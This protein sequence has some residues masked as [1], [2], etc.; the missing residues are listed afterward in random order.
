[1][2]STSVKHTNP[3]LDEN[4]DELVEKLKMSSLT[5]KEQ[6]THT[7]TLLDEAHTNSL[8][9]KNK[10]LKKNNH[11][12]IIVTDDETEKIELS[13]KLIDISTSDIQDNTIKQL[14]E[15]ELKENNISNI[16][17]DNMATLDYT[18][19]TANDLQVGDEINFDYESTCK[20]V[21]VMKQY[22]G[23]VEKISTKVITI[24]THQYKKEK[25]NNIIKIELANVDE[26]E[27]EIVPEIQTTY[28]ENDMVSENNEMNGDKEEDEEQDEESE[29]EEDEEED[30]EEEDE[31][32]DEEE[33]HKE[34]LE[35][36]GYATCER[37][38]NDLPK[39]QIGENGYCLA[40]DGEESDEE[41]EQEIVKCMRCN[42]DMEKKEENKDGVGYTCD[43]CLKQEE[44]Y[45]GLC[46]NCGHIFKTADDY[47]GVCGEAECIFCDED[48][49]K[50]NKK[51]E[52]ES[53]DEVDEL[54]KQRAEI[55][56]KIKEREALKKQKEL[57][58]TMKEKEK[59]FD[60]YTRD[61]KTINRIRE[62]YAEKMLKYAEKIGC[63]YWVYGKTINEDLEGEWY[64]EGDG[65][66]FG[67]DA[68]IDDDEIEDFRQKH[69]EQMR[70]EFFKT[71][72]KG[73]GGGGGGRG[74]TCKG[75]PCEI[76]KIEEGKE[77]GISNQKFSVKDGQLH[78]NGNKYSVPECEAR[79]KEDK[80][81]K[82]WLYDLCSKTNRKGNPRKRPSE[83]TIHT[84]LVEGVVVN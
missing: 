3:L 51:Q 76:V 19:M 30:E 10:K 12:L 11:K 52:E 50:Y 47:D 66:N 69:L 14:S 80:E 17:Q 1:M 35:A 29:E 45:Y 68:E 46:N 82:N 64:D 77:W 38:E 26:P 22:K 84:Y 72:T 41:E 65:T 16:S 59:E 53:D 5:I 40:C 43:E 81:F 2:Y 32:E 67:W 37:C 61:M 73:R 39:G 42:M 21:G 60:L 58:K 44:E 71:E 74:E 70:K 56:R 7:N 63:P 6:E 83:R 23:K 8:L 48:K 18:Q 34:Q 13:K 57:E 62:Q 33:L 25:M 27:T 36:H 55:E 15:K 4:E 78:L 28:P 9:N 20:G 79:M 24:D 75:E 49:E 31:E 54:K